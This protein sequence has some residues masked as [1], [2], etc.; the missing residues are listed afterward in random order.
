MEWDLGLS[1]FG[2]KFEST[3]TIQSKAWAEF[4]EEWTPTPEEDVIETIIPGRNHPKNGLCILMVLFPYKV[5][6]LACF[7]FPPPGST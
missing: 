6:E 3:S 2:L 7:L 4:I 5:Q 1:N